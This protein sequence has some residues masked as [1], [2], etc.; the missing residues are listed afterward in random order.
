MSV[1][2]W[3][4]GRVRGRNM[5]EDEAWNDRFW[6]AWNGTHEAAR[7]AE[8]FAALGL[9]MEEAAWMV[10][11]QPGMLELLEADALEAVAWAEREAYFVGSVGQIEGRPMTRREG[12]E[13]EMQKT[14]QAIQEAKRHEVDVL[15]KLGEE[16][17]YA[18]N[19]V[20]NGDGNDKGA[21]ARLSKEFHA[22]ERELAALPVER[23]AAEAQASGVVAEPD[24]LALTRAML[25][26]QEV[27]DAA[28]PTPE[29][30]PGFEHEATEASGNGWR[31]GLAPG[32]V[33]A[34]EVVTPEEEAAERRR[35][36]RAEM[37]ERER[38]AAELYQKNRA[39]LAEFQ[40]QEVVEPT[41]SAVEAVVDGPALP[42]FYPEEVVR[43][44]R[45]LVPSM[46]PELVPELV[47]PTRTEEMAPE[48]L[49]WDKP[50]AQEAAPEVVA[51]ASEPVQEPEAPQW[52]AD[53]Q[54]AMA[55]LGGVQ[56]VA[57]REGWEAEP[58][59]PAAADVLLNAL[60]QLGALVSEMAPEERA[61]F[62]ADDD[63]SIVGLRGRLVDPEHEP[64]LGPGARV[65]ADEL[66][67]EARQ[68]EA[69]A[70]ARLSEDIASADKARMA[71]I[72][73]RE[74]VARRWAE[75]E[76]PPMA[77]IE[78]YDGSP[79]T[80]DPAEAARVASRT[81]DNDQAAAQQ[82]RSGRK[83][84]E[85]QEEEARRQQQPGQ[86]PQL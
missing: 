74:E 2:S 63:I 54:H 68:A 5:P 9:G 6:A 64:V 28:A 8:R 46:V 75:Y 50:K 65:S 86:E 40:K 81:L 25:G 29:A 73:G 26:V 33:K 35:R 70:D 3:V 55:R 34:A 48:Q 37:E 32:H 56:E 82:R 42:S 78:T 36:G 76:G 67:E 52:E 27:V 20:R 43:G 79:M 44:A 80:P 38:A 59:A 57:D 62:L 16:R 47:L 85:E 45:L 84:Q 66:R 14:H 19:L 23:F 11:H 39:G 61:A 58:E 22:L 24:D 41:P 72:E 71:E 83:P 4:A 51:P 13:W 77:E 21:V 17:A 69:A 53:Q 1:F 30:V 49:M 15:V 18:E 12:L 60:D 7:E 10:A 31:Y